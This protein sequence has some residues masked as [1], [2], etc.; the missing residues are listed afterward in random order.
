MAHDPTTVE[1]AA[2]TARSAEWE[3]WE[4]L[5]SQTY[6]PLT[7]DCFHPEQP[8]YGRVTTTPL[9]APADFSLTRVAGSNQEFR[10]SK[11]Q[12]ARTDDEYLLASIHFG[13]DACL[14]QGGRSAHLAPGDMVFY[15]T[16]KPYNWSSGLEFEQV[17][18]QVPIRLLRERPGL[19]RLELPTAVTVPAASAAGVVA[20]FFCNLARVQQESPD[21]ADVLARSALD[22]IGSAVLLTAG[23][24]PADTPADS[25]GRERAMVY[26][27]D[28]YT[29]P[30][31]TVDEVAH[32]CY[33]SRRT[34]FRIFDDTSES[35]STTLRRMRVRHAKI[36]LAR[37]R[38]RS[39]AAVAFDSGFTSERH[40]YRV[41][42]QET[43]MTPGE[44]RQTHIR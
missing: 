37:D 23:E 35:L 27:H 28:H 40:F 33:I 29:D 9:A 42:R 1:F 26:L 8:F 5:M 11:T 22:L 43:G 20:G 24:R 2:E 44:Y 39:P 38:S 36:L 3:Q 14:S 7:I 41:F 21:Q 18:V 31:L 10:R 12:V 25:L 15:D 32:A 34:L 30:D 19:G 13:G 6:V 4:A 16:S 17:V